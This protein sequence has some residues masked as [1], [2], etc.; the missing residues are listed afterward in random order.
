M[1]TQWKNSILNSLKILV[2]LSSYSGIAIFYSEFILRGN[3][4]GTTYYY[5]II[6]KKKLHQKNKLDSVKSLHILAF[7]NLG[8]TYLCGAVKTLYEKAN[9]VGEVMEN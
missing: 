9:C 4:T 7:S 6:G 5:Y 1:R 2:H 8:S 3:C